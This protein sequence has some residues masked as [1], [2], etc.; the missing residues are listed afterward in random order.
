MGKMW[1]D[2]PAEEFVKM[3][4]NSNFLGNTRIKTQHGLG[5]TK[6]V[7]TGSDTITGYHQMRVAHQK[8]HDDELTKVQYQGHA[9]GRATIW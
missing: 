7:Q 1:E 4:S 6:W 5:A 2:L 8:Y 3:V 9:Y